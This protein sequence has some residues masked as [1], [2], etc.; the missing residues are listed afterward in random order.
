MGSKVK[1]PFRKKSAQSNNRCTVFPSKPLG[2][3][4]IRDLF[5]CDLE[6]LDKMR[7][8]NTTEIRYHHSYWLQWKNIFKQQCTREIQQFKS[9]VKRNLIGQKYSQKIQEICPAKSSSRNSEP[10]MS[11]QCT[12]QVEHRKKS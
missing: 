4:G 10:L 7:K 3:Y 5:F 2:Y 12:I 1:P 6:I 8:S 11:L 9:E